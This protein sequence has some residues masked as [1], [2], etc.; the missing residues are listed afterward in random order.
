MPPC[1][2]GSRFLDFTGWERF[3]RP[4]PAAAEVFEP[5]FFGQ[6]DIKHVVDCFRCENL[7]C[8]RFLLEYLRVLYFE[9]TTMKG[10]H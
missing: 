3:P 5:I 4:P 7:R 9:T 8:A 6:N 10:S 2:T 1:Q